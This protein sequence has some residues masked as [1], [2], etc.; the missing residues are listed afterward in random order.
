MLYK[1]NATFIY[2]GVEPHTHRAFAQPLLWLSLDCRI[3]AFCYQCCNRKIRRKCTVYRLQESKCIYINKRQIMFCD[4]F[5]TTSYIFPIVSWY[6]SNLCPVKIPGSQRLL[7]LF[8]VG[9]N[10]NLRTNRYRL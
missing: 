6:L 9:R 3:Y 7:L 8:L 10:S 2:F 1:I 5:T 4:L